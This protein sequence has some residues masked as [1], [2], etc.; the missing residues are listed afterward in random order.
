MVKVYKIGS[1]ESINSGEILL[2]EKDYFRVHSSDKKY[3][4]SIYEYKRIP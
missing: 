2:D 3:E 1:S 4:K